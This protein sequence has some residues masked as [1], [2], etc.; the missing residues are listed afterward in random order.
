MTASRAEGLGVA[1]DE[2]R[3]PA[4]V[5]GM[6]LFV[7]SEV[8]FFGGL[9]G[10][11]FSLR[12]AA[13]EWPPPGSPEIDLALPV[14]LTVVLLASSA[15]QHVAVAAVRRDR[16][17]VGW[18]CAT[19]ALGAVFLV[20]EGMEWARF[21]GAGFALDT[22]VFG[23]LFYTITGFHGLHLAAGLAMLGLAVN[24]ALRSSR[25]AR[26][27]AA[28]EAA[29]LYWHFVDVVWLFVVTSLYLLNASA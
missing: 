4:P 18:V 20:G 19:M 22:N 9:L 5:L 27:I 17:A 25:P 28:L 21:L 8:M 26:R 15:T 10:A 14:L 7:A 1:R 23:T 11:Y 16:S 12:A 2:E 6:V 24:R 13:P 3:I 29:T